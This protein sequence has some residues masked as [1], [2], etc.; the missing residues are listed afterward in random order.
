MVQ[1]LR[2][3]PHPLSPPVLQHTELAAAPG[4]VCP[5]EQVEPGDALG[6]HCEM[7]FASHVCGKH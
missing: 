4:G 5:E 7:N 1:S 3:I 2:S 6:Q